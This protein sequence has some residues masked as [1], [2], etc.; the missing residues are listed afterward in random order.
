MNKQN[1]YAQLEK[2][3]TQEVECAEIL[4]D[5]LS[6]ERTNL[7]NNPGSLIKLADIKQDKVN[8]LE[9]LNEERNSILKQADFE[10]TQINECIQWCASN[11]TSAEK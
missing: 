1:T 3:I 6:E 11:T 9:R 8:Q 2:L 4:L 7:A 10:T 5:I